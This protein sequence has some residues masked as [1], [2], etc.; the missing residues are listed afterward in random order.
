MAR[1]PIQKT[2]L[3]CNKQF[4][5]RETRSKFCSKTCAGKYN[6]KDRN[7]LSEDQKIKISQSLKKWH[8]QNPNKQAGSVAHS[9]AVGKSTKGKF[10]KMPANIFDVSN[11]SR[12]KIV[13]RL[14]LKCFNCEWNE[15]KCDIHHKFGKK[16]SDC[17]NHNFLIALCPNCHRKVHEKKLDVSALKTLQDVVGEAWRDFYFG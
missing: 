8:E 6:N 17:N 10:N 5:T 13:S 14:N 1:K 9:V 11:R 7:A 4:E 3:C 15:A 2:C 16:I 12:S